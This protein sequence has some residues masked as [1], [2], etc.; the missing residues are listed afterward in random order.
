MLLSSWSLGPYCMALHLCD[1]I[2][3]RGIFFL[4]FQNLKWQTWK[5]LSTFS[6]PVLYIIGEQAVMPEIDLPNIGNWQQKHSVK[7]RAQISSIHPSILHFM[8]SFIQQ[9]FTKC[10]LCSRPQGCGGDQNQTWS[11]ALHDSFEN[12]VGGNEM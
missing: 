6:S 12:T 10:L 4:K 5:V 11:L 1:C 9:V 3:N 8:Y 2:V 7:K